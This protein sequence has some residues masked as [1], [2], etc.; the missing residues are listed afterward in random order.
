[1][2]AT[3][4][5]LN[6]PNPPVGASLL[7]MAACK[8]TNLHLTPF[9]PCGSWLASDGGL[10]A[11]NLQLNTPNPTVGASLLAMAACKPTNLHLTPFNPCGS[12]LASD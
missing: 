11:T 10:P 6:A 5:Q 12:W 8:P 7:A 9:N 4:L 2:R 1:M 3:N